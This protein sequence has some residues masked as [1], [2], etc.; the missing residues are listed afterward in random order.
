ML[1]CQIKPAPN[2]I[3]QMQCD[4]S[5]CICVSNV[6]LKK[7]LASQLGRWHRVF[8]VHCLLLVWTHICGGN[9]FLTM[10]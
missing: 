1:S 6:S 4:V 7:F 8:T 5:V 2:V 9:S 3:Y 10:Y